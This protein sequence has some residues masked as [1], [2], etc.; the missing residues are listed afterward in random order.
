M[1]TTLIQLAMVLTTVTI[2]VNG[3]FMNADDIL[4][5]AKKAV[6]AANINQL[7]TALELYYLDHNNYPA[8]KDGTELI[9]I[10]LTEQ[11]IKN[12]PLDPS[13]FNYATLARG[14]D[15]TLTFQ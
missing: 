15:Y 14:S 7:S 9:E 2:A 6:N 11:Y 8:A 12:K 1:N 10:L 13:L 4:K 3:I 5:D